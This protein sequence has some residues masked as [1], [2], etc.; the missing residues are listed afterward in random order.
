[1]RVA[2]DAPPPPAPASV[3]RLQDLFWLSTLPGALLRHL[4]LHGAVDSATGDVLKAL[5]PEHEEALVDVARDY[6][7]R[8]D[9]VM[10]R[11]VAMGILAKDR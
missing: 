3:G 4:C 2:P 10:D 5:P 9:G 1:M 6:G 11:L 8:A 7:L